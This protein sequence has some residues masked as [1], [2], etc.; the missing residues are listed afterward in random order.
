MFKSIMRFFRT[1]CRVQVHKNSSIIYP[2][3]GYTGDTASYEVYKIGSEHYVR[4]EALDDA[5]EQN[6]QLVS[7]L[8]RLRAFEQPENTREL[9]R[10]LG[11]GEHPTYNV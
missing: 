7:W 1:K 4:L 3:P 5:L 6:A 11:S 10:S 9:L 2:C 8:L